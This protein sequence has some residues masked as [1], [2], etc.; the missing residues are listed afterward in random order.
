MSGRGERGV[1]I[2][3]TDGGEGAIVRLEGDAVTILSSV[4]APPGARVEAAL[5]AEGGARLR[6]KIHRSRRQPDGSY[7]LEGRPLDLT[8]ELRERIGRLV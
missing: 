1:R 8:R 5:V 6:F 2:E 4:A 3:W 7:L